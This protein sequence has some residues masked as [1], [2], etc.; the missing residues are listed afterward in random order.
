MGDVS[1]W[2]KFVAIVNDNFELKDDS[3]SGED[4]IRKIKGEHFR[5]FGMKDYETENRQVRGG[6]EKYFR[7]GAE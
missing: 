6:L 2:E 3:I 1:N 7:C 4:A 5:I